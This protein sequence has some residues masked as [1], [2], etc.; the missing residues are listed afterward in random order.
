M[1]EIIDLLIKKWEKFIEIHGEEW[2]TE[3]YTETYKEAISDFK[4]IKSNKP[5][6]EET[7]KKILKIVN[8]KIK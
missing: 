2:I 5:L 1:N 6:D 7:L 4:L 3:W 8:L